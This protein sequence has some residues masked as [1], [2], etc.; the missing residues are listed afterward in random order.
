MS[1]DLI[2]QIGFLTPTKSDFVLRSFVVTAFDVRH[3]VAN[4]AAGLFLSTFDFWQAADII[5]TMAKKKITTLDNLA[6]AMEKEFK[7][8]GKRTDEK[9]ET[10]ALMVQKG[11]EE[12]AKKADVDKRFEQV[13]KRFDKIE[14]EIVGLREEMHE[15]FRQLRLEIKQIWNKLEE[16]EQ[17]LGKISQT[18]KE[19]ADALASDVFDLRQRVEFLEN[20]IKELRRA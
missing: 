4:M 7:A 15:Q 18:S 20:Q 16:I 9:I 10:L 5:K 8:A 14:A 1:A 2:H 6:V 13:D 12:T 3:L 17:K 11:F 19:D